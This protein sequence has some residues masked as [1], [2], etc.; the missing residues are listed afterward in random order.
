MKQDD[1]EQAYNVDFAK[2]KRINQNN[3]KKFFRLKYLTY[4]RSFK[5]PQFSIF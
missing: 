4:F 5:M 2:R 1:L 3:P